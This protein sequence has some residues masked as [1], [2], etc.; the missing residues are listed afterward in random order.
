MDFHFQEKMRVIVEYM[1]F[2]EMPSD[3]K[4]KVISHVCV[5][6]CMCVCVCLRVRVRVRKRLHVYQTLQRPASQ[7]PALHLPQV[8]EENEGKI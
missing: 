8:K 2:R 3:I 7:A 1:Q 6:M 4:R 5:C